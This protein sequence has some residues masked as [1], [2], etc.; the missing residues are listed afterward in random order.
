MRAVLLAM[1]TAASL[2]GLRDKMSANHRSNFSGSNLMDRMRDVMSGH[3]NIWS[4]MAK[5][6]FRNSVTATNSIFN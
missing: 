4:E 3:P 1:A 2:L 6:L 5:V